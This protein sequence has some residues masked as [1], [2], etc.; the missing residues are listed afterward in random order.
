MLSDDMFSHTGE[1]GS[2]PSDRMLH[3]GYDILSGSWRTGENI[4]WSGSTGAIDLEQ[5]TQEMHDG[6]FISSEH[7]INICDETYEEIGIGID[8]GLFFE[9]G[10]NWNAAMATQN[11]A[12]SSVTP[13]PFV[14]GVVYDD[15]NENDLYDLGEGVSGVVVTVSGSSYYGQSGISGG[16]AVP[17]TSYSATA[18]V[19]FTGNGWVEHRT[20]SLEPNTSLKVDLV[21]GAA[22]SWY[23]GASVLGGGWVW[24]NWFG[25][26]NLTNEPWIFHEDHGWLYPFAEGSDGIFFWEGEMNSIIWTS[27]VVYPS[28]YRFSDGKWLFYQKGSKNPRW[29]VDL[30]TG[31]WEQWY[32]QE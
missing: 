1:A 21:L 31:V 9:E 15:T 14:T 4:A 8:A 13:G 2:S 20:V 12:L 29:F 18:E 23:D 24:L 6:L 10:T 28:I 32:F 11:F 19:T 30:L 27:E 26:F 17:L 3:A 16:Y 25:A 22:V 7:R 5:L